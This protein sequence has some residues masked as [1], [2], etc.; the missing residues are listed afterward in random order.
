LKILDLKVL[1]ARTTS[2]LRGDI[3]AA[4]GAEIN[5]LK[6]QQQKTASYLVSP[7]AR[8]GSIIALK[9]PAE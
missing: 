7:F 5:H 2:L 8:D 9:A 4:F 1:A 3:S 6:H